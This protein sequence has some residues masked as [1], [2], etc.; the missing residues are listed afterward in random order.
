VVA[1]EGSGVEENIKRGILPKM[2]RS[3]TGFETKPN[4]IITNLEN[5]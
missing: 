2:I 1:G 3:F 5:I 4:W